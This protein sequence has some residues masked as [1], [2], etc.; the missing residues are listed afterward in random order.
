MLLELDHIVVLRIILITMKD[1]NRRNTHSHGSHLLT[2]TLDINTVTTTYMVRSA[3]SVI[4]VQCMLGLFV[5][6]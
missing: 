2:H 6:A 1:F 3:S 5:F 4:I